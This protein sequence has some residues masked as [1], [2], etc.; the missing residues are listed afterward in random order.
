V[1]SSNKPPTYVPA[2]YKDRS[3]RVVEFKDGIYRLLNEQAYDSYL[4]LQSTAFLKSCVTSRKIIESTII[5][6]PDTR[7]HNLMEA[8]G[9]SHLLKHDK[10]PLISYPYEWCFSMLRDAALLHLDLMLQALDE[11]FILKD[12]TP[13]NIQFHQGS[14]VLIDLPSFVAYENNGW[15]AY[16]EFCQSFLYPLLLNSHLGLNFN[17]FLTSN[18][19]GISVEDMNK[20]FYGA[21][22]FKKG[23]FVHVYLQNMIRKI[24]AKNSRS[25]EPKV[26]SGK[27]P[28]KI[29]SNNIKN[30]VTTINSLKQN[31][32]KTV[33]SSYHTNNT[34]TDVAEAEKCQFIEKISCDLKPDCVWDVGCNTGTYSNIAAKH[35]K[36]VVAIDSDPSVIEAL[37]THCKK[38]NINN[39]IPLI[40]SV[41][42][43]SPALGWQLDER[44]PLE[45]RSKPD[46]VFFLAIIHHICITHNIPIG[47]FIAWCARL[48]REVV[49]EFVDREDTMCATLLSHKDA[50]IADYTKA[51]FE[52][53]VKQHFEINS[54]FPLPDSA[55]TLYHLRK[56]HDI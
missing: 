45:H 33:W 34:Y 20:L 10:I 11:Q 30:L 1:N 35:A 9:F 18:L 56:R 40:H 4:A 16:R 7:F 55:R 43:P 12:A 52:T 23:I 3:A 27:F 21:K 15:V 38:L 53:C 5:S 14:L 26:A 31:T 8:D 2:S 41:T 39:L 22:V 50:D 48:C 37:Y 44:S 49:I 28:V 47:D 46:L 29:I 17:A 24:S 32:N 13:F 36:L 42:E 6:N 54:S 19:A 25:I 51:N